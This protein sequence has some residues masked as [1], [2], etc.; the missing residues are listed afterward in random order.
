M[1]KILN[2][3]NSNFTPDDGL[4]FRPK[5]RITINSTSIIQ[6]PPPDQNRRICYFYNRNNVEL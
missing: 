5:Y 6:P 3:L 4:L 1:L 2:S